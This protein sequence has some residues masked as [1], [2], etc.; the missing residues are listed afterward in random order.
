MDNSGNLATQY[1]YDPFGSTTVLGSASSST[2]QYTSRENDS[3]GIYYY[4]A[5]Y[6]DPLIARFISEDPLGFRGGINVYAYG[7]DNPLEFSDPSGTQPPQWENGWNNPITDWVSRNA[8]SLPGICSGGAFVYGGGGPQ[9]APMYQGTYAF[10]DWSVDSQGVHGNPVAALVEVGAD[11]RGGEVG[12]GTVVGRKGV[13]EQLA[14]AGA[15]AG[16]LKAGPFVGA[17]T[18]NGANPVNNERYIGIFGE[19]SNHW[20]PGESSAGPQAAI[21]GGV[22][23]TVQ[24]AAQCA[25]R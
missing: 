14:F 7:Y 20:L 23:L 2:F 5:R 11:V 21:G 1:T 3:N 6:Y 12:Y 16:P 10:K 25:N 19:V 13:E 8:E 17:S 18:T 24:T 9:A 4:R 22:Y 15:E